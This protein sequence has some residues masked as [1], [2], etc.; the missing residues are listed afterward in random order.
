MFNDWEKVNPQRI[1]NIFNSIKNISP[2]QLAD[3]NLFD[4]TNLP[5][6]R[7]EERKEYEFAEAE[8]SSSNIDDSMII[9]VTHL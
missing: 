9:N 7:T 5:I 3:S 2:S 4:F 1:E 8:V 6:D